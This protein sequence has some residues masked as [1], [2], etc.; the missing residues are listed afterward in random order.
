MKSTQTLYF[1]FFFFTTTVLAS[2]FEKK[3]SLIT[4]ASFNLLTSSLTASMYSLVNLFGF[5]ILGGN[6]RSTL[7]LWTI[8]SESTPG[9]LYGLQANKFTFCIRNSSISTLS[10]SFIFTP[11]WK[12]LSTSGNIFTLT[13]SSAQ[14]APLPSWG[15][16]NCYKWTYSDRSL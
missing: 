2:H 10:S 5:Y 3:I 15:S 14:L 9:I 12:Y 8:N 11:T 16:C 7:N 6:N 4:P 13:N 1:P